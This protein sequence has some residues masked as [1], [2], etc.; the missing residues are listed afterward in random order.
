MSANIGSVDRLIRLTLGLLV[1]V[2][3]FFAGPTSTLG[4]TLIVIGVILVGTAA[5]RFCPLYRLVG[6]STSTKR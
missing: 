5:L 2:G 3:A 6:V 4:I 1:L